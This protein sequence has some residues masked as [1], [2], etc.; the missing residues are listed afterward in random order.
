[1][2]VE[3][4]KSKLI[5]AEDAKEHELQCEWTFWYVYMLSHR[6]KKK[7]KKARYNEY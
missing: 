4:V 5:A 1:M 6:E 2:D 7:I 3:Q